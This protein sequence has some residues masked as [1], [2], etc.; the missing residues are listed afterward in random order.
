MWGV[1]PSVFS[2][3]TIM[4]NFFAIL[5][6][7]VSLMHGVVASPLPFQ[8][9][10]VGRI[11]RPEQRTIVVVVCILYAF[12]LA[13]VQGKWTNT[14]RFRHVFGSIANCSSTIGYR[15]GRIAGKPPAKTQFSDVLVFVQGFVC[16]AFL[17]A[18]ATIVAGLGL[19]T[20]SQCY[21][22]IRICIAMYAA[23]KIPLLVQPPK[24]KTL[25]Y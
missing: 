20:E 15:A 24:P 11:E 1:V 2:S 4:M 3:Y 18:T 17:F 25:L 23:A 19:H 6:A 9:R 10:D 5:V 13:L 21:A 7:L 16:T 8:E 14:L 22:A 12:I